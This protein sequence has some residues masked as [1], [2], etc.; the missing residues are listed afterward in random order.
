MPE[1][2]QAQLRQRAEQEGGPVSAT[3][4]VRFSHDLATRETDSRVSLPKRDV[5][6]RAAALAAAAKADPWEEGGALS[7]AF[8]PRYAKIRD[9]LQQQQQSKVAR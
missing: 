5:A 8:N 6:S 7:G 4:S 3:A 2:V 9:V 1:E